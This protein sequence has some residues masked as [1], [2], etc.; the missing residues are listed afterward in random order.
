M[1]STKEVAKP[2]MAATNP[3]EIGWSR[4]VRSMFQA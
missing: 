4:D 3:A 2:E 1:T